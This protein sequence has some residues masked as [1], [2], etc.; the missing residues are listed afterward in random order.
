MRPGTATPT[1]KRGRLVT[2]PRA[3][4]VAGLLFA[5]LFTLAIIL[6]R[7]TLNDAAN[8]G[9]AW[10]EQNSGWLSFA[11]GLVPFSGIFFLWFIAVARQ[12]LGRFEDQ[13]FS[14]VFLGSGLVFL[15][16]V[17]VAAGVAGALLLGYARDPAGFGGSSTFL[18]SRDLTSQIFGIY[19]MRMAAIFIFSQATLWM[20][21]H[22]MPR[23]MA[24]LSY[25]AGL[26][27]LFSF[28]RSMGVM[29]VFPAWV[30][31][32]SCYILI[33]GGAE[34]RENKAL[35]ITPTAGGQA[36]E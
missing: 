29:I 25:A 14:T 30:F 21:T 28:T 22:V 15:C 17:F 11:I 3:G 16:M 5:V 32:V 13:F 20:R 26:V 2:T 27:L 10:L 9:S 18:L 8:E 34:Q 7:T 33:K 23:W 4:A 6:I 12:H 31:L 35:E 19:G 36:G 1:H 24:V